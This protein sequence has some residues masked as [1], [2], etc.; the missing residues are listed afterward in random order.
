MAKEGAQSEMSNWE[1][2]G[3]E[4]RAEARKR[5]AEELGAEVEDVGT[6]AVLSH[7]SPLGCCR[8]RAKGVASWSCYLLFPW[9]ACLFMR[10]ARAECR[11]NHDEPPA[12]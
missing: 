8:R 10:L 5:E 7:A 9:C 6:I 2:R 1:P 3:L 11:E 12:D 4:E